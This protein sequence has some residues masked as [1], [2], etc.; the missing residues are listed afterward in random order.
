MHRNEKGSSVIADVGGIHCAHVFKARQLRHRIC[1]SLRH[2]SLRETVIAVFACA[3]N[4]FALAQ[5][6]TA[7]HLWCAFQA[8]SPKT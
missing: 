6:M 8:S 7:R 5:N 3:S 1:L 4:R 2:G